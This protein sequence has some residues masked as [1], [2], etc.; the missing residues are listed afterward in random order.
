MGTRPGPKK[1]IAMVKV[2]PSKIYQIWCACSGWWN[3]GSDTPLTSFEEPRLELPLT[4]W[5]FLLQNLVR[6]FSQPCLTTSCAKYGQEKEVQMR[7][8]ICSSINSAYFIQKNLLSWLT[9]WHGP[10]SMNSK[11]WILQL[12]HDLCNTTERYPKRWVCPMI[13]TLCNLHC[14]QEQA[15]NSVHGRILV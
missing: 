4:S 12:L 5:L 1:V 8:P 15:K 13:K 2:L 3:A 6:D 7:W 10:W 11:A 9:S 14:C